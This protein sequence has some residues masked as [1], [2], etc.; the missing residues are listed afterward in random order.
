MRTASTGLV[1]AAGA[2]ALAGCEFPKLEAAERDRCDQRILDAS[3]LDLSGIDTGGSVN[4]TNGKRTIILQYPETAE[5]RGYTCTL[6]PDGSSSLVE[7]RTIP[8]ER[9]VQA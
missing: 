3:G 9:Q 4:V 8:E 1:A 7:Y 5:R 2:F 6:L